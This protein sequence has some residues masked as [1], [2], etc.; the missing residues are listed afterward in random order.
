[1]SYPLL[2]VLCYAQSST[3]LQKISVRCIVYID[4][5][6]PFCINSLVF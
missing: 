5:M 3:V 2:E 4:L 1:M 6:H